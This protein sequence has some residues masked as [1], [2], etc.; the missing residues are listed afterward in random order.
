MN[1]VILIGRLGDDIKL[2]HFEGGGCIGRVSMATSEKYKKKDGEK[3]EDTEWHSL[4]FLNKSAEI[5]E[6]Y[7]RKGSKIM[8][9]GRIKYRIWDKDD[10]T[11][12]YA[13]EIKVR[14]FEF[15]DSK[16]DSNSQHQET[17]PP[18]VSKDQKEED[19]DLPF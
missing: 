7:T 8:V 15:L 14:D 13:T 9:E 16:K 12:G 10:G 4:T 11:K 17:P 2:H 18:E 1:K 19:D 3:V 5:I 6:K